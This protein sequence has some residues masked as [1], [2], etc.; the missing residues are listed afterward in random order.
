MK[1][2]ELLAPAGSLSKLK[3]AIYYGADAVYVGGDAFSLRT[4]AENFSLD[5]LKE[6]IEFAHR[7][8]AKIYLALNCFVHNKDIEPLKEYILEIAKTDIDAVIVSDLGAFV[9]VSEL[10]PRLEIHIS[11]QA[12]TVNHVA[13]ASWYKM[14]AKRVVLAREL[15]Y[16]E[17]LEVRN[18]T[19]VG[20]ELEMF[21]HGA[22]CVSYSGRCLLS[23]YLVGRDSNSGDCAQPCRWKYNLVEEKRPGEF[24]PIEEDE[25]GS[26]I[27]NSKDLCL[28]RRIPELI[29]AG[30]S[31]L[32]IEGRVKTEYYV[33]SVVKVYR[34]AIDA[35]Y[36]DPENYHFKEEWYEELCKVSHRP[37][38][39][40]FCF[41]GEDLGQNYATSNYIREYDVIGVIKSYDEATGIAEIIQRNRFFRG[42]EIEVI[43][44]YVEGF[45]K[46]NADFMQDEKGYDINAAPH[47]EMIVRLM[48]GRKIL[49]N[50][51]LRKKR[52]D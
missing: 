30:V 26:F 1:K 16:E 35:Y 21:V 46:F 2:I 38:W 40:G 43:S 34:E 24:I 5:Q 36:R 8:G 25:R 41:G 20:L 29:N 39:E 50:S 33:A 32:K 9:L 10:A 31:S 11:T 49:P 42:D 23:N 13:A 47:A 6:G 4:A 28:I 12:N 18:K 52:E 7:Y 22:M 3:T 51:I 48:P 37:Y 17:I 15:T 45:Y 14:G 27:F 44:P 19:A